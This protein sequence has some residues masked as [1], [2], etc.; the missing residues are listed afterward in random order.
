MN[1]ALKSER[2]NFLL[3]GM[4]CVLLAASSSNGLAVMKPD[5]DVEIVNHSMRRLEN[6][7][8]RFGEHI[9]KWGWVIKRAGYGFYPHRITE[10]AELSWDDEGKHK[11]ENIDLRTIYPPGR[12][13]R[14]TFTA[15]LSS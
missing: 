5:V 15:R 8:A 2:H 13:G 7:Q 6:A 1:S 14:L 9:C 4:F 10:N 11:V 3:V 12:S